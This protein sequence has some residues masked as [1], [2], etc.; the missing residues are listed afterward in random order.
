MKLVLTLILLALLHTSLAT[1]QTSA[2]RIT[3]DELRN[4]QSAAAGTGFLDFI[5]NLQTTIWAPKP[6]PV[7]LTG[8]YSCYTNETA[9]LSSRAAVLQMINSARTNP[10][11]WSATIQNKY[12]SSGTPAEITNVISYMNTVAPLPALLEVQGMD[13]AAQL[14]AN[15]L[16]QGWGASAHN[17]CN[18]NKPWDRVTA[19]GTWTGSVGENVVGTGVDAEYMV[20]L[21][22]IDHNTPSLG[23]RLNIMDS[24]Y[25]VIGIGIANG[26]CVTDFANTFTCTAP[27]A[28]YPPTDVQ[29]NCATLG[30]PVCGAAPAGSNSVKLA[31][32]TLFIGIVGIIYTMF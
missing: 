6:N 20:A 7:A 24:S 23:H 15:Y 18:S 22:L 26:S 5:R 8:N 14:Q 25:T 31:V 2:T 9:N 17:G 12:S 28:S 4:Q 3:D 11:S 21:W 29:Y 13:V 10:S 27:C 1:I 30:Y 19:V 32:S 16:K